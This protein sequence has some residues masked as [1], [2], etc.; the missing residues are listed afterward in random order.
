MGGRGTKGVQ[1]S[2]RRGGAWGKT[3]LEDEVGS[4]GTEITVQS[5]KE[6]DL[7]LWKPRSVIKTEA[8]KPFSAPAAY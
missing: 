1:P 6:G 8:H 2:R 7:G 5:Q 4:Q 3:G